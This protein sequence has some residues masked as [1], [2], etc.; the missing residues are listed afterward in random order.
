MEV[1]QV[2][3]VPI[4]L[5]SSSELGV[6]SIYENPQKKHVRMVVELSVSPAQKVEKK[7]RKAMVIFF[8]VT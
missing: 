7:V 1:S 4:S 6:S 3:G 8:D 2:I 5:S